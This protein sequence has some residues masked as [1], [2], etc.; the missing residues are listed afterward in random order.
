MNNA[1]KLSR[2]RQEQ[3]EKLDDR[4]GTMFGIMMLFLVGSFTLLIFT[5]IEVYKDWKLVRLHGVGV[6]V[7]G[8]VTKAYSE[9][10]T[11]VRDGDRV[12]TTT[13]F[14]EARFEHP[15]GETVDDKRVVNR[16]V[17][18]RF[19]DATPAVT[20]IVTDPENA[21]RWEV[22]AAFEEGSN[23]R[24][25]ALAMLIVWTIAAVFFVL[26]RSYKRKIAKLEA[27]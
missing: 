3:I 12:D 24:W 2:A 5:G 16:R 7:T 17:Y 23:A 4:A 22:E 20:T 6:E 13:Y 19:V 10:T 11:R 26:M 25:Y 8:E 27:G 21:E 9:T 15:G 18:Q 14:I 1:S